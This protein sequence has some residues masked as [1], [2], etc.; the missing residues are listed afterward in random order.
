MTL[1]IHGPSGVSMPAGIA[2]SSVRTIQLPLSRQLALS[3]ASQ[4]SYHEN[5][6]L[7]LKNSAPFP[8]SSLFWSYRVNFF[9]VLLRCLLCHVVLRILLTSAAFSM[10]QK[11]S[12]GFTFRRWCK[13][14]NFW[15]NVTE[16]VKASTNVSFCFHTLGNII[17]Y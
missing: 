11:S 1:S 3:L 9:I 14:Q 2:G 10:T 5:P 12:I 7:G 15:P 13:L 8:T 17:I 16:K 6:V 4:P